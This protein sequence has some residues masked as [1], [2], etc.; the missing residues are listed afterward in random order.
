MGSYY[1]SKSLFGV[2]KQATDK[3]VP[4][5]FSMFLFQDRGGDVFTQI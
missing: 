5:L 4:L 3:S 1:F 2:R